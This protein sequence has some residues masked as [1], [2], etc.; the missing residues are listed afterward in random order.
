MNGRTAWPEILLGWI[1]LRLRWHNLCSKEMHW[2]YNSGNYR[3]KAK[4][5]GS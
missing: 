1:I 4:C 2:A 3:L 5:N